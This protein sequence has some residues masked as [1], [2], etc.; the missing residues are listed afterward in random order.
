MS[1]PRKHHYLSQ[2]YLRGFSADEQGIYQIE[3]ATLRTYGSSLKDAAAIRDYH[4]LDYEDADDPQAVEKLLSGYE[5]LLAAALERVIEHGIRDQK[6]HNEII[7]FVSLMRFRVPA[8]KSFISKSMSDLVRST[9]VILERN[10]MLPPPPDGLGDKLRMSSLKI[11]I[12]NWAC[13]QHMFKLATDTDLI[14]IMMD[15]HYELIEAPA[16]GLFLTSDQPVALFS[17]SATAKGLY[18][19]GLADHDI[20]L[21][22]P[23]TRQLLLKLSWANRGPNHRVASMSELEELNRRTVIMADLRLFA[24]ELERATALISR[25][26]AF[27]AGIQSSSIDTGNSAFHLSMFRPVLRSEAYCS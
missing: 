16:D 20:E 23:L 11:E 10:G 27:T 15:M 9:G 21:T 25:Y 22:F 8:F 18:G 24:S 4:I 7:S 6:D 12:R 14:K 1:A 5:G 2:F 3:K 19:A 26:K 13:L 17:P